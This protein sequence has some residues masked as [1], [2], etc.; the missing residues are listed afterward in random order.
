MEE[1]IKIDYSMQNHTDHEHLDSQAKITDTNSSGSS[2]T[3]EF[4]TAVAVTDWE[5]VIVTER[6]TQAEQTMTELKAQQNLLQAIDNELMRHAD[7]L[8]E[9]LSREQGAVAREFYTAS[10]TAYVFAGAPANS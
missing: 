9:Q 10:K 2:D 5:K 4:F 6:E 7:E 3:V 1:Y 8:G